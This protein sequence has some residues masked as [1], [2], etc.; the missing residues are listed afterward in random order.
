[1]YSAIG[2]RNAQTR[3]S[4]LASAIKCAQH[5]RRIVA[6]R[7]ATDDETGNIAQRGDRIVVVEMPAKTFLI[8]Q[9]RDAHDHRIAILPV[10]EELQRARLAADLVAGVVEIGQILDFRHR[11]HAHVRKTLGQTQNHGLVEQSIEHATAL[12]C[13]VQS[14]GDGVDAALLGDILTKQ[15]RFWI[16]AEQIV[17]GLI[18]RDG[19]VS[20]RQV[21][22][23]FVALPKTAT[24]FSA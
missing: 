1:M 16:L 19:H 20:R 2:S 23:Q 14:A 22:R 8:A 4:T 9:R 11:Q 12:E 17:Q 6:T 24:R 5:H 7:R 18:D 21:F 13:L 15:Q 3:P 10:G